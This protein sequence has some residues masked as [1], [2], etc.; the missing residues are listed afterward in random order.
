MAYPDHYLLSF[1]GPLR[2]QEIWNMNIRFRSSNVIT[3]DEQ[4]AECVRI[5][6]FIQA[7]GA[8]VQ[9]CWSASAFLSYVKFNR[10]APDGTYHDTGN[11]HRLDFAATAMGTT[12]AVVPNQIALVVSWMTGVSRGIASKGRVFMP[13]PF[14]GAL[15]TAGRIVAGTPLQAA[16]QA[17]NFLN[18]VNYVNTSVFTPYDLEACVVSRGPKMGTTWGE[19]AYQRITGVRIGDVPDTQRRRRNAMPEVYAVSTTLVD[20]DPFP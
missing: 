1:G 14:M 11:T 10:I 7:W 9:S 19:G 6:P 15:T 2:T 18:S 5:K 13:V 8:H 4:Q 16:I 20:D 3:A 17:A 12:V